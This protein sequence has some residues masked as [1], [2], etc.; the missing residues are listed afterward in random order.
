ME[1]LKVQNAKTLVL[2]QGALR[3]LKNDMQV[4]F[5]LATLL[6]LCER[7]NGVAFDLLTRKALSAAHA[8]SAIDWKVGSF[9]IYSIRA[10]QDWWKKRI[11]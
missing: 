5:A 4:R 11:P 7:Y 8:E 9:P 2:I 10:H 1:Q 3:P 6:F